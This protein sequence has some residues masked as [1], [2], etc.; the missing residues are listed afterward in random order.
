MFAVVHIIVP[1]INISCTVEHLLYQ[2]LYLYCDHKIFLPMA[3]AN[4]SVREK[5]IT[6]SPGVLLCSPVSSYSSLYLL[7]E[8]MGDN[9]PPIPPLLQLPQGAAFLESSTA[10]YNDLLFRSVKKKC[11][12]IY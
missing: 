12:N 6:N 3:A 1:A 8:K 9:W 2:G 10:I 7:L 11:D 5:E 4:L